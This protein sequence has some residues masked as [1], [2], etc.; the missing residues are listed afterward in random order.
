MFAYCNNNPIYFTDPSGTFSLWGFLVGAVETVGGV[1][2]A[3][4]DGGALFATGITTTYAAATDSVMVMDVSASYGI[5][6]A[7]GCIVIDFGNGTAEVYVHGGASKNFIPGGTFSAGYSVGLVENYTGF[8]AYSGPFVEAGGTIGHWGFSHCESPTN[9]PNRCSATC[10]TISTGSSAY[11]EY[12]YYVSVFQIGTG[13][14]SQNVSNSTIVPF[15]YGGGGG[16]AFCC[17]EMTR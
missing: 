2:T 4:F 12:D 7:G 11:V 9:D 15:Y 16:G 10:F 5:G 1:F 13:R 8:G 14:N 3:P 17:R 6:K